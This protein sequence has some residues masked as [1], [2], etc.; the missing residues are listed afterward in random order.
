MN[1]T[2]SVNLSGAQN[3]TILDSQGV[4]TITNDDSAS[5]S[6]NDVTLAE[7][8]AGTTNFTFT[9]TLGAAV[10]TPLTVGF[11]TAN[12]TAT[13]A[14]NDYTAASG[15]LSFAGSAGETKSVTV[16]VNGDLKVESNET[17]QVNLANLA[18][19][20]RNVTIADSQGAGSITNDDV[21]ALPTLSISDVTLAEGNTGVVN[22]QFDVTLSTASTATVTVNFA[23]A[24]GTAVAG[25]DYQ[26]TSG[27]LTFA[28]GQTLKTVIVPV[29]GDALVEL[30][31]TLLVNLSGVQNANLLDSQGVGT[32]TN[33]DAASLV[34][35][36]VTLAEGNAGTTNFTFTVTLG[37]AVDAPLTVG[38]STADGTATTVDNDYT[39]GSGTL[40]FTGN[41]GETKSVTVL[42]NGDLKVEP[43]E[44]FLVNLANLA[45][46]GRNVTI[47]DSQGAGSITN[48][49]VTALPT[50]SI[51]DV[52]LAEGNTGVVDAQFDVT[53]STASTATVTVN[54]ATDDG[55]AVAGGDYQATSGILTFAPGQT[56]KT[57]IVPVSG[58]ALVEL[59]ETLLVNLSGSQ[60]A[61]LLDSQG[62]GTLTNDDAASLVI[63][64]VTLA[65][66]N[67]GTT[68]F[69]FTVTLGAAVD[70]PLTVGF[71]T[72]DG[73]ATTVDNDYAAG[74]GTL[75]FAGNAGE[76]KSVTV[77]V[78][79]DLKV[80][81]NETFLVNLANL[82]AGGRNVTVAD[83][84]GAGSIT[85]D[86]VAALPTL[87]IS[88]VIS[89]G[90]QYGSC[91]RPI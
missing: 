27:I 20:G 4:A 81:S 84:Q 79:G 75:S 11:A 36:D 19:G 71:S 16:V 34:I 66:G 56:L 24:D 57:V 74:S 80:E 44:T 5:L 64:D 88:D 38:F 82:V 72:A 61:N 14:D 69:T 51:S 1:E 39:A 63:T 13:T 26:A 87:S 89:G 12:G 54:F 17:F 58:D 65:E 22:A 55:T 47:A 18:A 2:F 42:V 76:T 33:D 40:T 8:N 32:I 53:L 86:D 28:P 68:N 46:G 77:V 23:T 70:A 78:N 25:G 21:A 35:T 43:N 67:A 6:I 29:S 62:V 49:D 60:N 10:D 3:A 73:T 41:A 90:R 85:N 50:L 9:V 31:E 59:N 45:A 91:Q 37:A 52:S 7:G 30:T 83:S 15:T 48:D